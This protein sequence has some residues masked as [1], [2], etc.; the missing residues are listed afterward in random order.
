MHIGNRADIRQEIFESFEPDSSDEEEE[1]EDEEG[2]QIADLSKR[3]GRVELDGEEE[4]RGTGVLTSQL[5]HFVIQASVTGDVFTSQT[6]DIGIP[7]PPNT[8][9]YRSE[10]LRSFHRSGR[11]QSQCSLGIETWPR[12]L[13]NSSISEP[14]S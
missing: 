13:T 4:E 6:D 11:L 9:R 5:R 8:L 10:L 7:T 1:D 2:D 12:K 14:T 3:T